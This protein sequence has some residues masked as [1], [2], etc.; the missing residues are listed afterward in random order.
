MIHISSKKLAT[1]KRLKLH[2][3]TLLT[4][5]LIAVGS[6]LAFIDIK[7][8]RISV[9]GGVLDLQH[10]NANQDSIVNLNGKWALYWNRLLS[11]DDLK[12]G[13]IEPDMLIK[14][15]SY[16]NNN[17][18][19]S[20]SLPGF[21][22]ATYVLKVVHAEIGKPIALAIPVITSAYELYVNDDLLFSMGKVDRNEEHYYPDIKTQ[23]V[24]FTPMQTSFELRVHVENFAYSLG[25]MNNSIQLGTPEHIWS[26]HQSIAD[27]D[28]FLIGALTIMT[29]FHI[30]IFL[31]RREERSVIYYVLLCILTACITMISGDRLIY[32][33]VPSISFEALVILYYLV[34]CWGGPVFALCVGQ[35]YP[36]E[37]SRKMMRIIVVYAVVM[38]GFILITPV[39]LYEWQLYLLIYVSLLIIAY[40]MF[41]VCYAYIRE[42]E[43]ALI[44]IV[45]ALIVLVFSTLGTE[46]YPNATKM[47]LFIMLF[48]QA[49]VFARRLIEAYRN[50][51][52]LS[53][54]L[55]RLDQMKD[56]F[57]ANT[58]HELRTPLNGML[59]LTEAML[60]DE[61]QLND[62]Q[63]R[64]L[65]LIAGSGRRLTNLV[66]DILDYS[67]MKNGGIRLF[68]RPVLLN[69]PIHNAV[70]V[71]QQLMDSKKLTVTCDIPYDLPAVMGDENRIVQILYNLI[72]NAVK[73]TEKG[74]INVSAEK[75]GNCVEVSIHDTGQ[76][77]PA[78]K[79]ED[80]F[81][82]FEQV[83]HSL[84]RKYDGAGLGLAITKHLVELQGGMI[85][86]ESQLGKGSRFTFT[87]PVEP[88]DKD[89]NAIE[90]QRLV[91][92]GSSWLES[93]SG[94]EQVE[95]ELN[96]LIVDDDI[97]N[98]WAAA[99]LLEAE[100][101]GYTSVGSTQA[102][103]R[104]IEGSTDYALVLLD[105]MMPETSGYE[106]CR[107]IRA[108]KSLF[109]LPVL[110]LTA[111]T[112]PQDIVLGFESGANDYLP[113]P[114]K[115]E[116]L[117]AR[118]R[119][120]TNLKTSVDRAIAAETAF[121]QVQM[122]PHF[123]FNTLSAISSYCDTDP[124][125]AQTLIDNFSAYLRETFDYKKMDTLQ[126]LNRELKL[127]K[128]YV[129]IQKARFGDEL[130]VSFEVDPSVHVKI[131]V[132]SIQPLVE[133]AIIHGVRK[134]VG[135]GRVRIMVKN[136]GQGVR[137]EV[138]DDGQGIPPNKME[139][140]L[141]DGDDSGIGLWNIDKRLRQLYGKGLV[142][143]ST[144]GEGTRVY[145]MIP[146][147]EG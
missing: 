29:S 48:L 143:E 51:Q 34:L 93:A 108:K 119:T 94:L 99:A 42:R 78:D 64:Y 98:R 55:L 27:G 92:D 75:R 114:F 41:I 102:A 44:W 19:D 139:R 101:Y 140:L 113:K 47:G 76:G 56:E 45:T 89:T 132:F 30:V 5:M 111:K 61:E 91:L 127:V 105:I 33:V 81:K 14:V 9:Q 104:E 66:N 142:I 67:T 87:L 40:S 6:V 20:N 109:E 115:P 97:V 37:S 57:L 65:S 21:G 79:L 8:S 121:L 49:F 63:K 32:R 129:D 133:N 16:W 10:W 147:E 28:L 118:V 73:F 17:Q 84:T 103:W 15:P 38:T 11:Y 71:F 3:L 95:R 52:G 62:L 120:L 60:K 116:E 69:G 80:I 25:G 46:L 39:S 124:I 54:K 112:A 70:A 53:Q 123:L 23:V 138:Q 137:I 130:R 110:M 77:I 36:E 128:I 4:C 35:L 1:K 68:L 26:R 22:Y 82:S 122:K 90:Y 59:G 83:D 2:Y 50:E 12:D 31:L 131:P 125:L 43:N 106:L 134:K 126:S 136:T 24:E 58:S 85:E 141:I 88:E 146:M 86:V 145:Y 72:G 18:I 7:S 96:I 74:H 107:A 144:Q 13:R 100:G 117:L 135:A